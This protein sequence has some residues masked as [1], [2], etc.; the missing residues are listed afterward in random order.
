M[1]VLK[2]Y[3]LFGCL[4]GLFWFVLSLARAVNQPIDFDA[5]GYWWLAQIIHGVDVSNFDTSFVQILL[6]LRQMAYPLFLTPFSMLFKSEVALR[7]S[8]A[9]VQLLI[10]WIG[11]LVFSRSLS[12]V[13]DKKR[14]DFVGAVL[15][16]LPFP[17]FLITEL[18]QDSLTMSV[19]ILSFGLAIFATSY[20]SFRYYTASLFAM[21]YAMSIRTDTQYVAIFVTLCGAYVVYMLIGKA[22]TTP[23]IFLGLIASV[24]SIITSCLSIFL[25]R[26]PNYLVTRHLTGIGRFHPPIDISAEKSLEIGLLYFKWTTGLD[27]LGGAIWSPNPWMSATDRELLRPL[28]HW[29]LENPISG[30]ATIFAKFFALTDW[31]WPFTYYSTLPSQ[32]NFSLSLLNYFIV[33]N[34]LIG[35]M[36]ALKMFFRG[37]VDV[38]KRFLFFC[39][40]IA[41]VPY[42]LIHTLSHVEIRYGLPAII[43]LSVAATL[44][45]TNSNFRRFIIGSQVLILL[46]WVPFSFILSSWLRGFMP[47]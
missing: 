29:Y 22:I 25:L 36:L 7:V 31:D 11:V 33:G 24:C 1:R 27:P 10:Y 5:T 21:G 46:V 2:R 28:W 47:H 39:A 32:P 20:K 38:E 13:I 35:S 30:I 23:K 6:N 26:I 8:V 19:A 4:V 15:L 17:Y 16:S 41:S 12:T 9:L 37:E 18:L 43:G 14:S 42:L 40:L 44:L 45:F 34:G 3:Q